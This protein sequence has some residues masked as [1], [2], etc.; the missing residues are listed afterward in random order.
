MLMA[1]SE[2]LCGYKQ[3]LYFLSSTVCIHIRQCV[4]QQYFATMTLENTCFKYRITP[5]M[6]VSYYPLMT[7][8]PALRQM[9]YISMNSDA[10]WLEINPVDLLV[11]HGQM[12][13]LVSELPTE[14]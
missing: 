14:F 8:F 2:F 11:M 3:Q 5:K 12:W 9:V 4:I 13:T 6:T 10:A 1:V 7:Q